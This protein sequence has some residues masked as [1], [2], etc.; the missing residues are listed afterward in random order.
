MNSLEMP[1]LQNIKKYTVAKDVAKPSPW[2]APRQVYTVHLYTSSLQDQI[3]FSYLS[4]KE[5]NRWHKTGR[6]WMKLPHLQWP[7]HKEKARVVLPE[8]VVCLHFPFQRCFIFSEE[9]V[10]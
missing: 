8:A 3:H 6:S 7:L 10:Y 4:A 1:L 5:R 9:K 2:E